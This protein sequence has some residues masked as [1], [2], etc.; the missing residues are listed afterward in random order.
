MAH[1]LLGP[2]SAERWMACPGSVRFTEGMSDST[3]VFAAEGSLAHEVAE[4][5]AL[6]TFR[7][8]LMK[9]RSFNAKMKKLKEKEL[10]QDEMQY[11]TDRY[12][13]ELLELTMD[14]ESPLIAVE[15]KVEFTQY[16]PGGFGTADFI[17]I[18][19]DTL[20]VCDF[21]YGKGVEV[22]AFENKQMLLYALGA[23]LAYSVIYD[24]KKIRMAVIQPRIAN[25]STWECDTEY[26]L[27]FAEEAGKRARL[28]FD[29]VQEFK[30]GKHCK[31]CKAKVQC[32]TRAESNLKLRDYGFAKANMM[33]KE[34]IGSIIKEG[35]DLA[36]W[37]KEIKDW[38][39]NQCLEGNDVPGWKAVAGRGRREFED[40][41]MALEKLVSSGVPEE[42]LYER[43]PLTLAKIEK[44][45]AKKDFKELVGEMVIMKDG[46]PTLAPIDD[47][48]TAITNRAKAADVFTV[49]D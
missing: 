3:S 16:V 13:E 6:K 21:K 40:T 15:E 42:I 48:R 25:F 28:A 24:I 23:Y 12:V 19:G 26:L 18:S 14:L 29:G 32:R 27:S 4:L 17:A 47:K 39:L 45:I 20:V 44:E 1:A 22:D 36:A 7:P 2:S 33:T 43:K 30:A 37:V 11:F 49:L 31:F 46:K 38:A 34:E 9:T 5:K 35:E 8:D 41:D 10:Y